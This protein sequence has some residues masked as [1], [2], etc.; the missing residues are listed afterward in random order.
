MTMDPTFVITLPIT[1]S[2]SGIDIWV[3]SLT[4]EMQ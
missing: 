1:K 3:S 2:L 4:Y